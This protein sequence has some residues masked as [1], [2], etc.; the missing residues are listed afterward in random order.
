LK[1]ARA[2]RLRWWR[3][4]A[5]RP[6]PLRERSSPGE[7]DGHKPAKYFHLLHF[8]WPAALPATAGNRLAALPMLRWNWKNPAT[9]QPR[10]SV[11]A[12][13]PPANH[14]REILEC[15]S[16]HGRPQRASNGQRKCEAPQPSAR[17]PRFCT[18]RPP[19]KTSSG[20]F[21]SAFI[22]VHRRPKW[23]LV[24]AADRRKS[25][26]GRR[27]AAIRWLRW[28]C[29]NLQFYAAHPL[30]PARTISFQR[31]YYQHVG[32]RLSKTNPEIRRTRVHK[33][34]QF[35][36]IPHNPRCT[37]DGFGISIPSAARR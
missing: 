26:S 20:S 23:G 9:P 22:G 18:L 5:G 8:Q 29:H 31:L 25:T 24:F 28:R 10:L 17:A 13:R 12:I 21:L 36:P 30:M 6:G 34:A 32:L 3:H 15:K 35:R 1:F 33:K 19:R 27:G 16:P 2:A 14:R 11:S 4:V 37:A 7:T